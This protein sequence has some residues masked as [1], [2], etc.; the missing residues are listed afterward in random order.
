MTI[1]K[2]ATNSD[3]GRASESIPVVRPV[4][5]LRTAGFVLAASGVA[6]LAL[7]F[8][9]GGDR[10]G[11]DLGGPTSGPAGAVAATP[12]PV[13]ITGTL[14]GGVHPGG[15]R[16]VTFTA[17]NPGTSSVVI[18]TVRLVEVR[19]SSA[20]CVVADFTM[21]DVIQDFAG[22]GGATAT[23][24]PGAGTFSM[25]NT[26][27][28]QDRCKGVDLTLTLFSTSQ[29]VANQSLVRVPL[30]PADGPGRAKRP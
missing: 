5:R 4:R 8:C 9:T 24:L 12:G 10:V 20:G 11:L 17:A 7:L 18:G 15:S 13:T 29:S 23:A 22:A 25:A 16:P 14:A 28:N 6:S 3:A 1:P 2:L 21:P 19:S 26:M 30:D 27:T